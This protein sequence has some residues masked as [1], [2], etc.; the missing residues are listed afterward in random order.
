MLN[1]VLH[2]KL[3]WAFNVHRNSMKSGEMKHE[4]ILFRT[5]GPNKNVLFQTHIIFMTIYA[6][7]HVELF[8]ET[9]NIRLCWSI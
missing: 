5:M 2:D 3:L 7:S 9:F 6:W 8:T 1:H 4:M